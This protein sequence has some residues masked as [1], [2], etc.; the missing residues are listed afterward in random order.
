VANRLGAMAATVLVAAGTVCMADERPSAGEWLRP[1]QMGVMTGFIKDP[2]APG[3]I[4]S[5]AASIGSEFDA[6]EWVS[7]FR[8]AGASY[9]IFYDKWIDGLVFH[10]TATTSY[11]TPRDFLREVSDAC[12]AQGLPL[13]IYWNAAYDDNPEFAEYATLDDQGEPIRFPEPWPCRLLSMHS[14]FREKAQEQ[15]REILRGYGPIAGLW[16]DVYSQPYRTTDPYTAAAFGARYGVPMSEAPER[17]GEFVSDTLAGYVS[18]LRGIARRLQPDLAFTTNG[19]AESALHGP[20]DAARLFSQLQYMSVE[21]HGLAAMMQQ[22]VAADMLSRPMETADLISASW[23]SPPPMADGRGRAAIAEA[24]SAWC[25]GANAYFAITPDR[26]GR[27][28]AELG[29]LQQAGAWLRERRPLLAGSEPWPDVAVVMGAPANSQWGFPGLAGIWGATAPRDPGAWGESRALLMSANR[30]GYG[31]QVICDLAE[32]ARWPRNLSRFGVIV[33]PERAPMD[34][35]HLGRLTRYAEAGGALLIFGPGSTLDETGSSRQRFG[36]GSAL[37]LTYRGVATPPAGSA[38]LI[39]Y[40]D[41]EYAP[42]WGAGNLA[43]GTAASWASASTPM[44]HWGQVNLPSEQPVSR[45]Q[46]IAREGGYILRDFDVLTWTGSDWELAGAFPDNK[47]R[48]VDCAI[49]PPRTTL[50][51]RVLV[52]A[53]TLNDSPRDLADIEEIATFA[54]DGHRYSSGKTDVTMGV[55]DSRLPGLAEEGPGP[56]ALTEATSARVLAMAT[57]PA[58][59]R[60]WP[61]VAVNRVGRGRV[62]WAAA[63]VSVVI[64]HPL[65]ADLLRLAVG[66]PGIEMETDPSRHV[67]LLRRSDEGILLCVIDAQ[68]GLPRAEATIRLRP[69]VLGLKGEVGPGGDGTRAERRDGT[70][71][72]TIAPDPAAVVLVR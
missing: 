54:P 62:V 12:H 37:G 7:A 35:A 23:F 34:A 4:P 36:L 15:V 48:V 31:G 60:E 50:G 25:Q 9:L 1:P 10:N 66:R 33:V 19:S 20:R 13:V 65:F 28:G 42:D 41:S 51:I 56:I 24:A 22:S 27:F 5:W 26:D 70:L 69:D 3:D 63:P 47:G 18:D 2:E 58:T 57:D 55:R 21:G 67:L 61:Y 17:M 64:G 16:L 49:D 53:E 72:L 52:R 46:V 43:D 14:P 39:G 11:K 44:P 8:S 6:A 29:V 32:L 71:R 30:L 38:V 59:G 45:V 40:A 68:P